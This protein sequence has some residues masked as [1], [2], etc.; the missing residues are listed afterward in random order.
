[1]TRKEALLKLRNFFNK[2]GWTYGA[3]ARNKYGNE[4]CVVSPSAVRWCSAGAW[5]KMKLPRK[6][7]PITTSTNDDYISKVSYMNFLDIQIAGE[8]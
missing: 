6:F 5:D 7:L 8:K 3:F 2:N 4:V 1:M